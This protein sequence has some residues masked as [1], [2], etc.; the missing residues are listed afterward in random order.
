MAPNLKKAPTCWGGLAFQRRAVLSFVE[1]L[2]PDRS[3]QNLMPERNTLRV[4]FLESGFPSVCGGE[5]LDV[6]CL[7]NPAC[8]CVDADKNGHRRIIL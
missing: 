4:S 8:W 1:R 3:L 5:D 7:A 2:R 6:L